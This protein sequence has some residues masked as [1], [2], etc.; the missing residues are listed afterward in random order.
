MKKYLGITLIF[1]VISSFGQK[2]VEL[3]SLNYSRSSL[4]TVLVEIPNMPF[5]DVVLNAYY[6]A[7]FPEKYNNHQLPE[8]SF[9][10]KK[11]L[12]SNAEREAAGLKP[13]SKSKEIDTL[14]KI[15]AEEMPLRIKKYFEK[16]RI[17][18]KLVAKWFNRDENGAFDMNLIA[19]RG[20]YDATLMEM[21]IAN[22]KALGMSEV[23]DAG[24]QLLNNTFVVVSQSAFLENEIVA[25]A[26]K[27]A[28]YVVAESIG[29]YTEILTKL[30]ADVAYKAT[31]DGYS[32]FTDAHLYK[33]KWNDSIA[34]VF[35]EDFWIDKTNINDDRRIAFDN[36]DIFKLDYVGSEKSRT[37]VTMWNKK[38]KSS[39]KGKKEKK[40]QSKKERKKNTSDGIVNTEEEYVALAT[41]RNLHKVMVELQKRH[42][43]FKS[44]TPILSIDPITASIGMKEG[45]NGGE[46]FEV[47]E[48]YLDQDTGKTNYDKIDII[49]V[50][51]KMVW[52]NRF[53]NSLS[54]DENDSDIRVT[55]FK[56]GKKALRPGMLIRQIK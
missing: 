33:L 42:D 28:A 17:G 40:K 20:L 27:A 53:T 19:D 46:K 1:F 7:P 18:N 9:D 50:N 49:K 10:P 35:Y 45:L 56:K 5:K 48:Q 26:I 54:N 51:K 8:K 55:H 52:D 6:D 11:Y 14:L 24:E 41:V 25:A 38:D 39:G 47:F 4:H 23:E 37:V 43:I 30:A 44:K 3:E 34:T 2:K 21:E 31:K 16:E 12:I 29:G 15:R 36:S 13:V 32:V 22:G